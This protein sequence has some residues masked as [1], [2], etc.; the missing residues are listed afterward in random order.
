MHFTTDFSPFPKM[1]RRLNI[2]WVTQDW[3]NF[4]RGKNLLKQSGDSQVQQVMETSMPICTHWNMELTFHSAYGRGN[5]EFRRM[6]NNNHFKK[7]C[8]KTTRLVCKVNGTPP[9]FS[10]I[11][12][13]KGDNFCNYPCVCW[14]N[15]TLCWGK[16]LPLRT[17]LH[18]CPH[19]RW[20]RRQKE[21][22]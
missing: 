4:R 1:S 21:N 17:W 5:F 3:G 14:D 18:H 20:E 8:N 16:F 10:A 2:S 13:T 11:S 12:A 22:W 6:V 7:K 9:C 19:P 15:E